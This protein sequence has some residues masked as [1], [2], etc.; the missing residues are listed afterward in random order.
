MKFLVL[1][2]RSSR[3]DSWI[4]NSLVIRQTS[5]PLLCHFAIKSCQNMPINKKHIS[6]SISIAQHPIA[7]Q[8]VQQT[9]M[10]S[11]VVCL[12]EFLVCFLRFC[13]IVHFQQHC[14]PAKNSNYSYCLKSKK[15][16]SFL[17][18]ELILFWH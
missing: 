17:C 16:Y 8:N 1:L 12:I 7:G 2:F 4:A 10:I 18:F 15:I 6:T 5:V 13:N 11:N 3:L 9:K 14:S